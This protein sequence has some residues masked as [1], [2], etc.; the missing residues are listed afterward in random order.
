MKILFIISD[1]AYGSEKARAFHLRRDSMYEQSA[2]DCWLEGLPFWHH[3]LVS[4][5]ALQ[6]RATIWIQRP[7]GTL[8]GLLL[9]VA[10]VS[11]GMVTGKVHAHADGDHGHDHGAQMAT[12]GP[13]DHIDLPAPPVPDDTVLHAHDVGTTVTAFLKLPALDFRVGSPSAPAV[14]TV[15]PSP[16]SAA[17]IPPH[18]PPIA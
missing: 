2:V 10:M 14:L 9:L 12:I 13:T 15:T 4:F 11:A 3:P 17:R 6:H 16:P 5:R 7:I 18:R 1:A 8:A